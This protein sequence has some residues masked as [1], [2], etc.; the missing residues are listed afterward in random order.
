L[1]DPKEVK[2]VYMK[3]TL[4]GKL[5]YLTSVSSLKRRESAN[6]KRLKEV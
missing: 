5:S 3:D 1:I 6:V 2:L 4:A